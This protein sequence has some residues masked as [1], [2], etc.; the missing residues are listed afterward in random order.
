MK[1]SAAAI[2]HLVLVRHGLLPAPLDRPALGGR[3]LRRHGHVQGIVVRVARAE[4]AHRGRRGR[5]AVERAGRGGRRGQGDGVAGHVSDGGGAEVGETR[6][7]SDCDG[8]R[9][10]GQFKEL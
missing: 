6:L 2:S 3:R 8:Q 10:G 4:L 9:G 5:R 7:R 1:P